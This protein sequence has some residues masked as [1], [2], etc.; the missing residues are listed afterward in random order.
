M[1]YSFILV[2]ATI[3]LSNALNG[4]NEQQTGV[5]EILVKFSFK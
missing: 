1:F 3:N 5:S 2:V 4:V